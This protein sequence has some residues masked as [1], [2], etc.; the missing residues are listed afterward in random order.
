MSRLSIPPEQCAASDRRAPPRGP[1]SGSLR[2]AGP[3][4][5]KAHPGA[6]TG[7][8]R[9]GSSPTLHGAPLPSRPL[10]S[11]A[12][13]TQPRGPAPANARLAGHLADRAGGTAAH[14]TRPGR[15]ALDRSVDARVARHAD[16]SGAGDVAAADSHVSSGVRASMGRAVVHDADDARAP[17]SSA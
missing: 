17:V 16:R 1:G 4:P 11:G 8:D 12:P 7:G 14:G 3:P 15:P 6:R 13:W 10:G 5:P 9:S 2:G